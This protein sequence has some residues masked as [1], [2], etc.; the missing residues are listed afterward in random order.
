M[1][2]M[3]VCEPLQ[4]IAELH[5]Q[6]TGQR[7]SGWQQRASLREHLRLRGSQHMQPFL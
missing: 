6:F 7:G 4:K 5:G 2:Q 3:H 1:K